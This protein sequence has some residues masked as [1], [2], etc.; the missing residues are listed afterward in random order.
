MNKDKKNQLAKVFLTVDHILRVDSICEKED[1]CRST[2]FRN[3]SLKDLEIR[4]KKACGNDSPP[5]T[6]N[7]RPV[8]AL[9]QFQ[10][11]QHRRAVS[12]ARHNRL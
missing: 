6:R 12:G 2:Y 5:A 4:D 11:F 3:L 8:M 7:Q 1:V 9:K 10:N